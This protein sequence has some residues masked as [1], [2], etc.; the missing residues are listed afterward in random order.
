MASLSTLQREILSVLVSLYGEKKHP[1]KSKE[2]AERIRVHPGSV[3]NVMLTLEALG[4]VKGKRGP[5]GGYVPSA[6]VIE[7]LK[8][9]KTPIILCV[10]N[11]CSS[12]PVSI[13]F[14]YSL[15]ELVAEV[16]DFVPIRSPRAGQSTLLL[17]ENYVV[18]G[19]VLKYD[20]R[21]RRLIVRVLKLRR[22]DTT[23]SIEVHSNA[24]ILQV[25]EHMAR[26]NNYCVLVKNSEGKLQ[27][28]VTLRSILEYLAKR[29]DP[30]TPVN[31]LTKYVERPLDIP[32]RVLLEHG[33][34]PE[35][36]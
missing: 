5:R 29:G 16:H 4:L 9:T 28:Y 26:E 15:G 18:E 2:I 8:S 32:A 11:K 24:S 7:Y 6:K 35:Q 20:A 1:V 27:G 25:A 12:T 21:E 13:S 22:A 34:C 10:Q 19:S 31:V 17:A 30:F 33:I 23:N 3:R 14:T 36:F